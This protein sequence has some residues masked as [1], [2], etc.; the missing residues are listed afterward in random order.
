MAASALPPPSEIRAIV[1]DAGGVLL[2][3]DPA[4]MRELLAPFCGAGALD[5]ETCTRA[6]YEGMRELD[7]IG[8][9]DYAHADRFIARWLEIG[10]ADIDAAAAAISKLYLDQ[11]FVPIRG[12]VDGLVRLRAA[13]FD[14]AIV[15]NASGTME[16][17][18]AAHRICSVDGRD[19]VEVRVVVDSEV[20]GVE[21]PDPA[22]FAFA[23]DALGIGPEQAVYLGDSVHFDVRGARAAGLRPVHVDPYRV[24]DDDDHPHTT[25]VA[26]F[27]DVFLASQADR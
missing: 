8:R 14:L 9:T 7:R 19:A 22:I 12:V 23:L 2:V 11:P 6:H 20:V 21:K 5:D 18:L 13:G 16:E 26:G 27:A 4:A 3:P 15:S 24:C 17:Q 25:S 10:G 1:L